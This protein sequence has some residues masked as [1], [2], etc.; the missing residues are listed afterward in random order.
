MSRT[1]TGFSLL[2]VLISLL[3]ISTVS[4]GLLKEQWLTHRQLNTMHQHLHEWLVQSNH[5][6]S[7]SAGLINE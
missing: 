7:A 6:E 3:I 5:A 1:Q 4:L 2:E